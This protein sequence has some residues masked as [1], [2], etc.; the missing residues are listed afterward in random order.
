[1]CKRLICLTCFILVLGLAT[2]ASAD[3]LVH[4]KFDETSGSVAVD[5]SGNGNDGT[6]N[7]TP[8]WV[9]GTLGNAFD[10]W[11]YESVTLP[12]TAMGLTSD[13]GS[14]AFWMNADVIDFTGINTVFWAG[15]NTDGGGFGWENEMHVHL[16]SAVPG[17]WNGG[18]L[19]FF[20]IANPNTFLHTDPPSRRTRLLIRY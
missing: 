14:V 4:Y 13:I 3:L 2:G 12:A 19:S 8:T 7:G 15:D 18:E 1:M 11:G 6:I 20:A 10:F 17:T 5:A 9:E 16:E